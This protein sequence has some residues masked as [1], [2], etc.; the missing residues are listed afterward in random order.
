MEWGRDALFFEYS[1]ERSQI[2]TGGSL[3]ERVR[4]RRRKKTMQGKEKT[5]AETG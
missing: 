2:Y 4:S 3:Q 5:L 1:V